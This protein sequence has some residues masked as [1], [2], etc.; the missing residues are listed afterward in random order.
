MA[1]RRRFK[2]DPYIQ[3]QALAFRVFGEIRPLLDRFVLRVW[4]HED[5]PPT[6][7]VCPD[8]AVALDQIER[9]KLGDM[10]EYEDYARPGLAALEREA[11]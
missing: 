2:S 1:R 4:L 3:R 9:M 8:R 7:I 5:A 6:E 11:F 10:E